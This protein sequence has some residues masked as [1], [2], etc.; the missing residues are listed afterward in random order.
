[1][2]VVAA[3]LITRVLEELCVFRSEVAKPKA[4][5][6]QESPTGLKEAPWALRCPY[7]WLWTTFVELLKVSTGTAI[8]FLATS[9]SDNLPSG[10]VVITVVD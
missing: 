10:Y 4:Q 6:P 5:A 8:S 1:M 3:F 2:A 9:L 7:Y